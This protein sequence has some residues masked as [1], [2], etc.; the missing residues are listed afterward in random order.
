[1]RLCVHK[2]VRW[3]LKCDLN[4]FFTLSSSYHRFVHFFLTLYYACVCAP[5]MAAKLFVTPH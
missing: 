3:R 2:H 4:F 5:Q 1:M